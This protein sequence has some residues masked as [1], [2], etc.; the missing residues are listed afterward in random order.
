MPEG[1]NLDFVATVIKQKEESVEA[2][3][4]RIKEAVGTR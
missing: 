2:L 3:A 1:I 4:K